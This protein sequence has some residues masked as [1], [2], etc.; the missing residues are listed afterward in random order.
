MSQSIFPPIN[1]L[2]Q[3]SAFLSNFAAQRALSNGQPSGSSLAALEKLSK[4]FR[5]PEIQIEKIATSSSCIDKNKEREKMSQVVPS[6]NR[7]GRP[8]ISGRP[9]LTCDRQKIVECYKKGMKKIHIAKQLGITHSCVSKVLRRYAETGEI[10][11]KACRTAS[12]SCP[13]SAEE[14]DVRYCKHLQDNTIRLFFSIENILRT[15]SSNS[16]VIYF[17]KCPEPSE[18]MEITTIDL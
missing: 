16:R 4:A 1:F 14:H 17:S 2:I 10:V 18:P 7:Y 13:G 8:Y 3:N 6:R 15:D 12:C 9:L 5:R 11:A